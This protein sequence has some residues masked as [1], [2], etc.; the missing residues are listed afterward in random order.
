MRAALL[1]SLLCLICGVAATFGI[2][3]IWIRGQPVVGL[4]GL[5]IGLLS[6]AISPLIVLGWRMIKK[7]PRK[8]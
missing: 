3:A 8:Q 2:Q 1:L 4:T 5:G 6:A 7:G